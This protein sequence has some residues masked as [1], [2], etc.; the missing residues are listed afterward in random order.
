[1]YTDA[2]VE[3]EEEY[4]F[5]QAL[6]VRPVAV[7]V[8]H[9]SL[10]AAPHDIPH[11]A[12]PL[13]IT[14]SIHRPDIFSPVSFSSSVTS[15]TFMMSLVNKRASVSQPHFIE[16]DEDEKDG[17]ASTSV[18]PFPSRPLA[19][20]LQ[21]SRDGVL[22][23]LAVTQGD[24]ES[25][26]F[27]L[28]LAPLIK[29]FADLNKDTRPTVGSCERRVEGM[30]LTLSK[31]SYF[32]NLGENDNGDPMYTLGRMAF[33]MFSPTNLVCSLQGNFNPVEVVNEEERKLLLSSVP[34]SLREEV[35]S[36]KT[37]LRTYQ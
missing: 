6:M 25:E 4:D 7:R 10:P 37:V 34:K 3:E 32:S 2:T 15:E 14:A 28:A 36:G 27:K 29:Y 8:A 17:K 16:D 24:V 20:S 13:D 33:D 30:W 9:P 35:E 11:G 23:A 22:H 12:V 26:K 21:M 18:Q 19:R 5:P 1:M 31:P